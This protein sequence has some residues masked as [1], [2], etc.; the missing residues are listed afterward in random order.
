MIKFNLTAEDPKMPKWAAVVFYDPKD[1]EIYLPGVIGGSAEAAVV[2]ALSYDGTKFI[3]DAG[4]IYAPL[5]WL[6]REHPKFKDT[7]ARIKLKVLEGF[8]ALPK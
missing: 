6:E 2:L 3:T 1:G 4:H 5:S 7:F 8:E